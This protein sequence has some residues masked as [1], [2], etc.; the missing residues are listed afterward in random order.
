MIDLANLDQTQREIARH[1]VLT[2]RLLQRAV[3]KVSGR[4]ENAEIVLM[5]DLG[6]PHSVQRI[7][8]GFY[9][10]MVAHWRCS[11]PFVPVDTTMNV[12][13]VGIYRLNGEWEN[14]AE[15]L[16][17]VE[18]VKSATEE[19]SSYRW[20]F[21]SGNHFITFA[22]VSPEQGL[23]AGK[24]LI[25]HSSA[26]EFK[27][28]RNGLYPSIGNW[29]AD[30]IK[31]VDDIESG[32]YLRYLHGE[33]AL[34][35]FR[36]AELLVN[37]NRNRLHY[38]AEQMLGCAVE[39]VLYI[40]HYGMPDEQSVALGCQWLASGQGAVLLTRP[41]DDIL[42]VA[43]RTGGRNHILLGGRSQILMPHGLGVQAK[44]EMSI[45]YRGNVVS[46]NGK[47]YA[48]SATLK[49]NSLLRIRG[50]NSETPKVVDEILARC[51]AT[52]TTRLRP[53]FSY[54]ETATSSSD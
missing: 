14:Y 18:T 34:R 8:G 4:E 9:T 36:Q 48:A 32:R 31:V 10:G 21:D 11:E 33:P 2:E 51:P 22:T 41:N 53:V 44:E 5:P 6:V 47:E 16:C 1:A 19:Q 49:R 27:S 3:S 43:P 50:A 40:P 7:I 24:Y 45:S 52:I 30:K 37:Y 26:A 23:P 54:P 38:F 25:L 20:N 42:V 35:V 29:Y 15:W 46:M 12:C 28:Q 13:G 39:E 17:R